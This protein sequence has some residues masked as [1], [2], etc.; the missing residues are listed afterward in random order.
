MN[1]TISQTTANSIVGAI[2]DNSASRCTGG[3]VY[4]PAYTRRHE[5]W[6][7]APTF[8]TLALA[9][10]MISAIDAQVMASEW[11]KMVATTCSM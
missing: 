3:A 9:T 10:G 1:K 5:A 11:A 6:A 7:A 8:Y 4:G 2:Y